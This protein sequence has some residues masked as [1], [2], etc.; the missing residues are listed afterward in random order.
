MS[1]FPRAIV[2]TVINLA[3]DNQPAADA[4]AHRHIEDNLVAAPAAEPPFRERA[5][6]RIVFERCRNL[7]L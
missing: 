6:I 4:G 3:V 1:D 7:E 2:C 5:G